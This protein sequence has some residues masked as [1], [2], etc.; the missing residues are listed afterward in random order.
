[1]RINNIKPCSYNTS[2]NS[3]TNPNFGMNLRSKSTV[4]KAILS[5]SAGWSLAEAGS[6]FMDSFFINSTACVLAISAF[7]LSCYIKFL[8]EKP[9]QLAPKI[10]FQKAETI[11]EAESFAKHNFKIKKYKV[12]DLEV[13]NWVNEGLTVLSNKCKGQVYMPSMIAYG[14]KSNK[15]YASYDRLMDRL[16]IYKFNTQVIEQKLEKIISDLRFQ[17]LKL[18]PLGNGYNKFLN[19]SMNWK[20]LSKI[21][22][23]NLW[24]S[25]GNIIDICSQASEKQEAITISDDISKVSA[26]GHVYSKSF[27]LLF[28]EMGHIFDFKSLRGLNSKNESNFEKA[29]G[30]L[31]IP[32]YAKSSRGEFLAEIF[33]GIISGDKFPDKIMAL[34][35]KLCNFKLPKD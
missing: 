27:D 28:H 31:V 13:A 12:D 22:K 10:D 4:S 7:A 25:I 29:K 32:D 14:E 33:A 24:I 2:Q 21:E 5:T 26:F 8:K 1:M 17:E 19:D 30:N 34:F 11:E 3:R 9:L 35:T 15:A 6:I 18:L 23:Q 16:N 20:S